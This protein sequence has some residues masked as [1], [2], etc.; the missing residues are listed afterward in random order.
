MSA[1]SLLH[2]SQALLEG[3]FQ[4]S[5]GK[6][7]PR[8]L[9]CAVALQHPRIAAALGERIAGAVTDVLGDG[10]D[11]VV[12]PALGGLI[13]GHEVG[14]ALGVRACF[15]ERVDG[16]MTMRRG[17]GLAEGERVLMVEDVITT[18]LSSRE[19]LAVIRDLGG[20]PV[21]TASIANRSGKDALDGLPLVSLLQPDFPVWD[22]EACPLCADGGTAI[23]PGSRPAA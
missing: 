2:E 16:S 23:K 19:T 17:F 9:Q 4:L 18:G 3:H 13:I 8:Y 11:V 5:S 20:E 1:E 12:S 22:P 15:T 7:S 10:P 14:R 6:H 21:A